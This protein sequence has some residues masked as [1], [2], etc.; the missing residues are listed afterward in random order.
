MAKRATVGR[1]KV[2]SRGSFSLTVPM[3]PAKL[4]VSNGARYEATIGGST[5]ARAE[6]PAAR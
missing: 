4:A 1:A 6:A 3:P 2:N 5:S